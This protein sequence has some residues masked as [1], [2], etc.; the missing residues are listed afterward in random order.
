LVISNNNQIAF[1]SDTGSATVDPAALTGSDVGV[2][3]FV[4]ATFTSQ[5]SRN[6]YL[7]GVLVASSTPGYHNP[8]SVGT[9]AMGASDVTPNLYFQ[10]SLADIAV[11]NRQLT[12]TEVANFYA[13]A[14]MPISVS[15]ASPTNLASFTTNQAVVFSAD[16]IALN[17]IQQLALYVN[18]ALVASGSSTNI[19]IVL[20][21]LPTGSYALT[22]VATDTTGNSVTS[23]VVHVTVNLPG[24]TLIDFDAVNAGTGPAKRYRPKWEPVNQRLFAAESADAIRSQWT[25]FLH[26]GF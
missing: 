21:N 14:T 18:S 6:I 22:A 15:I 7:D 1:Y 9:F 4:A 19:S 17:G 10:G 25:H 2:W 20:S 16:A 24:T 11:F 13:A 26:F 12:A 3:H 23:A 5:V 8:T